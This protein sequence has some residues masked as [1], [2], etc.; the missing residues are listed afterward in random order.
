MNQDYVKINSTAWEKWSKEGYTWT[1]PITHEAFLYAK[2]GQWDV[3]LA[4][5]RKVPHNWFPKMKNCK[6]LGLASGG[7]QQIPIFSA[8]GAYCVVMDICQSQLDKEN[9][10][11]KR[12]GYKVETIRRDMCSPFPFD[13]CSFDMIFHPASN[14]YVPEVEAI[15]SECYRVLRPGGILMCGLDYGINF[16][17]D[18]SDDYPPKVKHKLPCNSFDGLSTSEIQ[19][20]IQN[21]DCIQFS[22]SIEE[23]IGGQLRAGFVLTDLLE[24][25]N[26]EG[27]GYTR[28]FISQYLL[29]R[30]IK[31]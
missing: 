21:D 18:D 27:H 1:I 6:V 8:L 11:A 28:D 10:I 22:H 2:R 9:M 5:D 3:T 30:S 26:K 16:L 15:W 7:G 13:N 14:S 20:K 4:T 29:T 23:Q 24:D 25:R 12:E 17:F 19:K 31:M